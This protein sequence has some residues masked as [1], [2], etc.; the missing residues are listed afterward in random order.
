MNLLKKGLIRGLIPFILFTVTSLIWTQFEGAS[1]ISKSL[2]F[3]GLIAF[4]LGV[5]SVIYEVERWRFIQQILVHYLVML[6]TVFPT[7]LLSGAYPVDS[8]RDVARVYFLFNEMGLI[9]FLSTYF[10]F[11]W[12]NRAYMREQSE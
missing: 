12:R 8:I 10:M 2:L 7:L 3:Y 1:A 11:K 5:A 6:V 4:F 9:L